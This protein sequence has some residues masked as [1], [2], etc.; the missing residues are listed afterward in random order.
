MNNNGYIN[1]DTIKYPFNI[2]IEYIINCFEIINIKNKIKKIKDILENKNNK[3]NNTI[4]NKLLLQ[5]EIEEKNQALVNLDKFYKN[6]YIIIEK[7]KTLNNIETEKEIINARR[8]K[9]IF[10]ILL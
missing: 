2:V 10:F 1:I 3:K 4:F 5:N 7:Y 6:I 9:K 8:V